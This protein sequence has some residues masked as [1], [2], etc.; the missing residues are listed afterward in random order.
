MLHTNNIQQ[1][2]CLL[3]LHTFRDPSNYIFDQR[4]HLETIFKRETQ[5]ALNKKAT[6]CALT[7]PPH[8][9][10]MCNYQ[11]ISTGHA[12]IFIVTFIHV[13]PLLIWLRYE[14]LTVTL[15]VVKNK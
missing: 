3:I 6:L 4:S 5:R 7:N 14:L 11:C 2:S 8:L 13:M 12:I 15:L 9:F 1:R 10:F